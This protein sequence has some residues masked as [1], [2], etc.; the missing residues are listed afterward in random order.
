MTHCNEHL[1]VKMYEQKGI[2]LDTLF[3]LFEGEVTRVEGRYKGMGR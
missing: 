1:Q 2:L 3:I